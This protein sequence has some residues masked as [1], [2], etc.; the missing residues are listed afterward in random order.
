M[1]ETTEATN[2]SADNHNT[3]AGFWIRILAFLIDACLLF[4]LNLILLHIFFGKSASTQGENLSAS[5]FSFLVFFLPAVYYI[6]F[7][8][9][10]GQTIGKKILKLKVIKKDGN[11]M[12]YEQSLARYFGYILTVFTLGIGFLVVLF[13]KRK[14][15][16]HDFIAGTKVIRKRNT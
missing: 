8:A 10:Y 5:L 7:H 6:F 16:L 2:S 11:E 9:K 15:A 3:P 12:N 14:R 1:L 4:I 13:N